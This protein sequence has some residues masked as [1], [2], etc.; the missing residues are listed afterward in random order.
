MDANLFRIQLQWA[1]LRFLTATRDLKLNRMNKSEYSRI[2][3]PAWAMQRLWSYCAKAI[4]DTTKCKRGSYGVFCG[5]GLQGKGWWGEK[6]FECCY[7]RGMETSKGERSLGGFILSRGRC[8]RVCACYYTDGVTTT[9]YRYLCVLLCAC[10]RCINSCGHWTEADALWIFYHTTQQ[11][12]IGIYTH[13]HTHLCVF[14]WPSKWV[15]SP[16]RNMAGRLT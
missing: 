8:V 15:P 4:K 11:L 13:R 12:N 14:F 6:S 7:F 2:C 9:G 10:V 1:Q 5:R 3:E 16:H